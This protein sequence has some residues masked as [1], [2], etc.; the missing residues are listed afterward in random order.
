MLKAEFSPITESNVHALGLLRQQAWASTYRGIYPD[1]MIDQFDFKWHEEK[2]L[3]RMQSPQF[4]HWF[5]QEN[6]ENIGYLTLRNADFLYLYSLYLLPAAQKKGYGRQ[7]MNFTAYFCKEYG[8]T[9]FRCH[10]Q[11]DN[12]NA[13]Q[14]YE[15]MGGIIVDRDDENIENWQNTVVFEFSVPDLL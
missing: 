10:C 15:K 8:K 6:G 2:D 12:K 13:M 7:A 11:P 9:V 5:I 3:L 1:E 4:F 14:F